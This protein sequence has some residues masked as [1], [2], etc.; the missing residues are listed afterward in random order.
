M[1]RHKQGHT[2]KKV[3]S[4]KSFAPL[5]VLQ[6]MR[7]ALLSIPLGIGSKKFVRAVPRFFKKNYSA[8][9]KFFCE[10]RWHII[11]ALGI[12]TL[13][14]II[15]FAL[16]IFFREKILDFI[17]NMVVTL[18][19]KSTLGLIGFILFNNLKVSFIAIVTGIGIGIFPLAIGIINGYLL[20]FVARGAT[21]QGGAL[22]MWQLFPHGIFELP[23]VIF[24]I[25]IGLKIG[26]DL[27]RKDDKLR[28][29]FKEGLRFFAFVI[30]PLLLI[31][32]II[33]GILVG[34]MS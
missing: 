10:S 26:R 7:S 24:S 27:F 23:A 16:P 31:A 5:K 1:K 3:P 33:E 9:W 6:S 15:G 17:A 30:F 19:G 28:Y 18:E 2:H 34:L 11:F 14:F 32:G 21:A 4:L 12:F 29:N 20:G 22:V 25:G 8:C 13:F